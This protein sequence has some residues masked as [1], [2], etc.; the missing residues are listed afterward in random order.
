MAQ[1]ATADYSNFSGVDLVTPLTSRNGQSAQLL[2]NCVFK[3]SGSIA[4][5]PGW[6]YRAKIPF[7]CGAGLYIEPDGTESRMVVGDG[8]LYKITDN[9]FSIA[10]SGTKSVVATCLYDAAS[11]QWRFQILEDSIEVL[12]YPLG[13][14]IN[15]AVPVTL[16]TLKTQIDAISGGLFVVTITGSTTAPAAYLPTMYR[17]TFIGSAPG[18]LAI[19]FQTVSAIR[20]PNGAPDPFVNQYANR[21]NSS[22]RLA[23]FL[24]HR[25]VFY[26]GTTKDTPKKYDTR[27]VYNMGAPK[28]STVTAASS[29]GGAITANWNY[30]LRTS[31]KD[32]K[33]NYNPGSLSS[34]KNISI[35]AS[36]GVNLTADVPLESSGYPT[37]FA[38]VNGAQV[39][40]T[41]ITVFAGHSLV[42]GD[43]IY[44]LDRSASALFAVERSVVSVGATTVQISG[45]AVN[46]NASDIISSGMLLE[47]YRTKNNGATLYSIAKLPLDPRTGTQSFTDSTTDANVGALFIPPTRQ[48]DPPPLGGIVISHQGLPVI[49]AIAAT[50]NR[51][52][53]ADAS[54][55]EGFPEA[56]NL[57]DCYS[58]RGGPITALGPNIAGIE[59]YYDNSQY[60]LIGTLADFQ[61]EFRQVSLALGCV[62]QNSWTNLDTGQMVWLSRQGPRQMG[63]GGYPQKIGLGLDSLFRDLKASSKMFTLERSLVMDSPLD[64]YCLFYLCSETTTS[65]GKVYADRYSQVWVLDYQTGDFRWIGPWTNFNMGG[66]GIACSDS[67]CFLPRYYEDVTDTVVSDLS[68]TIRRGDNYDYVDH[69]TQPRLIWRPGFEDGGDKYLKKF[70]EFIRIFS[71]DLQ[72]A[73]GFTLICQVEKNYADSVV[74]NSFK[75]VFG[76][77]GAS[78]GFGFE[79]F[80]DF[81]WGNPT[82]APLEVR[83]PS[84]DKADNAGY[85]MRVVFFHDTLYETP[86]VTAFGLGVKFPMVKG[87]AK[88]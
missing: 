77:G 17:E 85:S 47:I 87:L 75:A 24:N 65:G 12:N 43:L 42:A 55:Q 33:A 22:F 16:A 62:N 21:N 74:S 50:P 8:P 26:I 66:G 19:T 70:F 83:I 1:L 44:L 76:E 80:G 20:K 37:D 86:I 15:T 27:R 67:V 57:A 54:N 40:V 25:N 18:I 61:L 79:P 78:S 45:A 4:R 84:N 36:S 59:V 64:G 3:I 32:A 46:V 6:K 88:Q 56:T 73:A 5:R 51:V 58:A 10:Y 63:P 29:G 49:S 7:S 72:S 71:A 68:E 41:T 30:R 31:H 53:W 34:F 13:N 35:A 81:A 28:V 82:S 2:Q 9:T 11:A 39:G 23:T 48:P 60:R 69:N 52:V 14:A 38:R